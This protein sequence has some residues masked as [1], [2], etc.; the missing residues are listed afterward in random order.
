MPT[1]GERG[2]LDSFCG[3]DI[4]GAAV[5][6]QIRKN[7]MK[8]WQQKIFCEILL[9]FITYCDISIAYCDGLTA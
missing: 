7:P 5:N 2:A 9:Q 3:Y 8:I 1:V 6:G 4:S